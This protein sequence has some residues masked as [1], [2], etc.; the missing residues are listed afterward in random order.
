MKK[1]IVTGASGFI[2]RHSLKPLI[3][4]G[5]EVHAVTSRLSSSVI[6]GC[7]WHRANLLD[8]SQIESLMQSIQPSHLLHFA[9]YVIPGK[10]WQAKENFLWVQ[11]SLEL[12][13]RFQEY[14]GQ[15]LVI[16]GTC[17]E[18]DWKYGY[19]SELVTPR[20]PNSAYGICK[21]GLQEMISF[22]SGLT[23]LSSAWG[24]I[25]WLYGPHEYPNR[26]VSSVI[27]SILK[28]E[29]ARCSHGNQ[30]RD[31]LCVQDVAEAFVALLESEVT[32]TV[33]IA[34]GQPIA[35]K[36]VV[37][38]IAAII[39]SPDLIKLGAI[40]PAP[41][42][43]PLLVADVGRLSNEVGWCPKFN[44]DKGLEQTIAWWENHLAES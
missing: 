41:N 19:C 12:I 24:R 10:C 23:G 20:H 31:F 2:G 33:N 14:G 9:W 36:E 7:I 34:S 18:Y 26:L 42:D 6:D 40:P 25:F 22:Y 11:A 17:A 39:G 16:A 35:I 27:C 21:N 44:L 8:Y 38:K 29:P 13:R 28:E 37:T 30:I 5:F 4:R 32:G 43:Q 3:E 1:I 15:R